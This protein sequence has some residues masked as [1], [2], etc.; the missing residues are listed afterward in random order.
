MQFQIS[1]RACKNIT[2]LSRLEF[3]QKLLASNFALSDVEDNTLG[4]LNGGG[5]V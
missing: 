3:I 1:S 5:E 4:P 2:E